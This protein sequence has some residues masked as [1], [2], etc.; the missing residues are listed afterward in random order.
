[1]NKLM[2]H[3]IFYVIF[4]IFAGITHTALR[5]RRR[6][7]FIGMRGVNIESSTQ[8]MSSKYYKR[9]HS[10]TSN[11]KDR[12]TQSST[13]LDPW[14]V[15]GFTDGSL[16]LYSL[17]LLTILYSC[18]M[19]YCEGSDLIAYG[20]NLGSSVGLSKFNK[21]VISMIQLPLAYKG[22][23][24]GLLLSDAPYG[25]GDDIFNLLT[26]MALAHLIC[27]DGSVQRHGLI[28]C[29]DS[30]TIQDTVRLLN[31][32]I[33]RYGLDCSLRS[34]RPNQYRIY[35][36]EGSMPR[37]RALVLPFMHDSMLY[38]IKA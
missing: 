29:T 14:F 9:G 26:P 10:T 28:L 12:K 31:V 23:F 19:V 34:P 35:I 15:T 27:G 2:N 18:P 8:L 11:S 25:G 38:K 21:I 22:I 5:A 6:R 37:L 1:M 20:S 33:V 7:V 30:Y 4:S 3:G 13:E 24:I 16:I 36:R 32:L 17:I